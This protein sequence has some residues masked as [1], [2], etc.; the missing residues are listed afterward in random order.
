MREGYIPV[1][2]KYKSYGKAYCYAYFLE[3]HAGAYPELGQ[4]VLAKSPYNG[5]QIV[6]IVDVGDESVRA[7]KRVLSLNS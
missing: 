4:K 2:I 1:S 3:D 6:T 7:R 5:V